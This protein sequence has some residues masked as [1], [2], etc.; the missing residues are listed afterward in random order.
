MSTRSLQTLLALV[1]FVL[2]GWCLL[3]PG[4]VMAL[5]FRPE[6]QTDAPV[7]PILVGAFGAQALIAG[8]FA[9]FSRFT[10]ATFVAYGLALAP[11]FVFDVYFYAVRPMLTAIGMLDL[12][13]NLAMLGLC[14]AG[15]RRTPAAA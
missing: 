13:G 15:W 11:F 9:A 4:S 14:V 3:A 1:F 6:F 7:A 12:V 8:L 10:R 5:C 2:G